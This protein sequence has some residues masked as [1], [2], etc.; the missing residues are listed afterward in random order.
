MTLIAFLRSKVGD[1]RTQLVPPAQE[2][3]ASISLPCLEMASP[4][5]L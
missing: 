3:F 4:R 1:K 5:S 2:L